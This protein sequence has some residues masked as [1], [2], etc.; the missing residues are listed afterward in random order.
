MAGRGGDIQAG[1]SGP[2]RPGPTE[3][4][5]G[6]GADAVPAE[7]LR[8]WDAAEARLFPL[9][10]ARPDEY[11]RSLALIQVLLGWLRSQ[12]Q[13]VPALLA[14]SARGGAIVT[15][16]AGEPSGDQGEPRLDEGGL[17][18]GVRGDLIA[19]AACAMRYRELV[20]QSAARGRRDAFAR[21]SARGA[22]WAVIEEVGDEARAPYLPYQRVEAHVPSG[23]VVIISIEPDETLNAVRRLD[24]GTLDL[25][26]GRLA[27][28]AEIGSYTSAS[29]FDDA[30]ARARLR[31]S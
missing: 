13:D 27:V 19:A 17:G 1:G 30:V 7:T 2:D 3:A 18:T 28:G 9:V 25:A 21:A 20:A 26:S 24:E 22:S 14:Q 23:R 12:C 4:A 8:S 29:E 16:A 31:L 11:E 5:A 6:V 15:D 10:M